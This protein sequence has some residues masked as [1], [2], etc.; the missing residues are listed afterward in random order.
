MA[1]RIMAHMVAWYPDMA[2]SLDVAR[3]LCDGGAEYLEI[4]FPFSDPSADGP[5]IQEA[6][7]HALT[8][9]FTVDAGFE[10]VSTVCGDLGKPVFIMSY[11]NLVFSRGVERFV[12]DARSAGAEGLIIPDLTPGYDEGLYEQ[13]NTGG[14]NV[15]PVLAPSVSDERLAEILAYRPAYLYAAIRLGITGTHTVLGPEV[16]DFVGKLTATGA[17]VLAGF[18]ID[19]RSQVEQLEKYVHALVVGSALVRTIAEAVSDDGQ[20][21]PAMRS[22]IEELS[23]VSSP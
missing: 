11:A 22:K 12:E 14:M 10:L 2:R 21:Y 7:S 16:F 4:Q 20:V 5:S 13:G 23:G 1:S 17:K 9:G 15:I 8:A 6:C 18:G 19:R 3:A